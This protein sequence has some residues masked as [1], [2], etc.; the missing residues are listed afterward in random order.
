MKE[1]EELEGEEILFPDLDEEQPSSLNLESENKASEKNEE[2]K[3]EIETF[4]LE[5]S[6]DK[7]DDTEKTTLTP[8]GNSSSPTLVSSLALTLRDKGVLTTISEDTIKE[9]KEVEELID[10]LVKDREDSSKAELTEIQWKYLDALKTGIPEDEIKQDLVAEEAYNS[11]TEEDIIESP[12]MQERIVL[13]DLI[14]QGVAPEKAKK[15]VVNA[16]STGTL[17]EDAKES[18]VSL[19]EKSKKVLVEKTQRAKEAQAKAIEE[20]KNKVSKLKEDILKAEEI[21]PGYKMSD[22]EKNATFEIL[23]KVV[24]MDGKTPLNKIAAARKK[25]PVAFDKKVALL[26]HLTKDFSTIEPILQKTKTSAITTLKE[27]IAQGGTLKGKAAKAPL[28]ESMEDFYAELR[29]GVK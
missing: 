10:A 23:T 20:N 4:T 7:G 2:L 25:D 24:E 8:E 27:Q 22:T 14:S 28:T 9:F 21:I 13:N 26:F 6:E 18:L 1:N 3:K 12:E 5:E 11:L 16:S 17:L 15:I 29:K 19:Q